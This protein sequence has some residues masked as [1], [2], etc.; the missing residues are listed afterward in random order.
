MRLK[1]FVL[2]SLFSPAS[3]WAQHLSI[4]VAG[5]MG[6][7]DAFTDQSVRENT[8]SVHSFS[9]T[10]D[11]LVGPAIE[12][13]LPFRLGVEFDALYRPLHLTDFSNAFF[14]VHGQIIGPPGFTSQGT[15]TSWEFPLLAK[16]R[17]PGRRLRPFLEAGPSF[18][19]VGSSSALLMS[20]VSLSDRGFSA[21]GGAEVQIW[22]LRIGPEVRYTRW[23]A[24]RDSPT[25]PFL[26]PTFRVPSSNLNQAELFV[27]LWF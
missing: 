2:L 1:F 23:A 13:R 19:H 8:G 27:E 22:K 21:G 4:G 3:A 7:T 14:V 17:L 16:Y 26:L 18:R 12:V 25:N 24:D 6:V 9:A 20:N 5:G 11:Y 15:I 10:K